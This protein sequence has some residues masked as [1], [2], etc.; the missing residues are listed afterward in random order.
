[1]LARRLLI[2]LAVLLGL[3]ALASGI[4]PREQPAREEPPAAATPGPSAAAE[5]EALEVTLSASPGAEQRLIPVTRG[6][7]LRLT[8]E[9]DVVDAVQLGELD[10]EP[11]E[12]DSPALFQLLADEPGELPIT[13]VDAERR[14]GVIEVSP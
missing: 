6:Q 4:A 2:L 9:G 1:V 11:I 12:P 3:T 8:V 7:T 5:P 10:I 13:L 14:L